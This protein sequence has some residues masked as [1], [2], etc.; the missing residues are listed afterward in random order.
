[1][2]RVSFTYDMSIMLRFT[3]ICL[4]DIQRYIHDTDDIFEFQVINTC[5]E[6]E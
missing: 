3:K 1:M 5:N 2:L 4:P 6:F